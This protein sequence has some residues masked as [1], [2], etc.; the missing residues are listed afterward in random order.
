MIR[1]NSGTWDTG[2]PGR[3]P[4]RSARRDSRNLGLEGEPTLGRRGLP[5]V[6]IVGRPNVG[7]STLFNRLVGLRKA[8]V[9][10]TPGVTRDTNT[11]EAEWGRARFLVMDTGGLDLLPPSE[12]ISEKVR[13]QIQKAV[14]EAD[15]LVFVV[16]GRVQVHPQDLEIARTLRKTEKPI[17]C[18]V[19]K[20]DTNAHVENVYPYYRLGMEPLLPVSAE[21]GIGLGELLDALVER[22]PRREEE[23]CEGP[24]EE[25]IKIAVV[26]R[27]NVG[28]ST[29]VNSLLGEERLLVDERPGTTRDAIDTPFTWENRAYLLIDTAGI[30][31]KAK[32]TV[33]L[34]KLAVIKALQSLDRCDVALLMLDASEEAGVQDAQIGRYVLEKG[35]SAVILLNKWDLLKGRGRDTRQVIEGVRHHL[36]HL[37]FVPIVPISALTGYNLVKTMGWIQRVEE[38]SRFRVSTGPLNRLLEEAV[39]AHPPPSE[40][41]QVTRLHYI[42]QVNEAPPTFLVFSNTSRKVVT[43]YQRYLINQIRNR[44][45][46]KGVPIR[47]VFRKKK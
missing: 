24:G 18:A 4:K 34:E 5:L 47:L 43:S 33:P 41:A 37:G 23:R 12:G 19:N 8:I 29:L 20:I 11:G 40:G 44:F 31:K 3:V 21:H 35:K 7:K 38:A 45:G 10:D 1:K 27:P 36:P 14:Q 26:G 30:R 25:P 28:K 16:D 42:T 17:L 46:F 9:E 13:I 2:N 15:V 6:A 32:V 39:R 22:L